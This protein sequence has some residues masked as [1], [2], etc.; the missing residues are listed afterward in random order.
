MADILL[1]EDDLSFARIIHGFLT[2]HGYGLDMRHNLK[3]G[4]KA[5]AEK[6]YS[7]VL[8]DY[9]LP[10][11]NGLDWVTGA[12]GNRPTCPVIIMTSFNDVRTAV[13]AMR[14]G[15]VDYIT[16]PV[17]PEELLMRI[18][19]TLAP[20]KQ[21]GGKST[22]AAASAKA[23]SSNF[24]KGRS[25]AAKQLQ[26]HIELLAPTKMSVIIQGESGTGK[27]NV[28]RSIHRL[29]SRA[30]APFVAIDCGALPDELAASELFGHVKGAFTGALQDKTGQFEAANGGTLFL[31]EIGNLSYTVQIKLLRALQERVIQPVGSTRLVNVDVRIIAAT[32][33][34]LLNSVKNGSFREDLYHRLNEFGI[35][36]PALRQRSE[37]LDEFIQFFIDRSNE[38][39]GKEIQGL[40][41]AA[42]QVMHSYDWPGNLRELK[43]V[44]KRSVLLCKDALIDKDI[45]PLEM[46]M[47]GNVKAPRKSESDLKAMNE[48]NERELI[49]KTLREVRYN[50]SKA[51][52]LLNI[53]RKTLYLKLAKYGIDD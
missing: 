3:D 44:I 15:V 18:R 23:N 30:A 35:K 22:A 31:D 10:D 47:A 27:E 32:N 42:R 8:L 36:V 21:A 6:K 2:K 11:G 12:W 52:A 50:K 53:D 25:A 28:A 46:V 39:L 38:E 5:Q 20:Q 13:R 14:E 43:N 17:N 9:H 33:D 41:E 19:E 45:L 37:D 4:Q 24:V 51:A 1:I 26:S 48:A 34:D 7:L 40:T 29:S 49:I 16:K